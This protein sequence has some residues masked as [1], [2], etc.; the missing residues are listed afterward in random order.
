MTKNRKGE[1]RKGRERKGKKGRE[2]CKNP[3][4]KSRVINP[5]ARK[6]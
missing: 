2:S 5:K 3:T 6:K 4:I 1:R